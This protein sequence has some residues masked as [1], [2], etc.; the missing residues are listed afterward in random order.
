MVWCRFVCVCIAEFLSLYE[1]ERMVQELTSYGIDTHCI[2]VNQLLNPKKDSNCEQCNA[3]HNMQQKYL[4]Q[5][6]ELYEDFHVVRLPQLLNE[7]RGVESLK[8]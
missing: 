1:T 2:V 4:E 6:L 7:V 8:R 3:R 5:I